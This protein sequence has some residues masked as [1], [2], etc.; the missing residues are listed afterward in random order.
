MAAPTIYTFTM[1]SKEQRGATKPNILRIGLA[2][3][4]DA[5]IFGA[6][7]ALIHSVQVRSITKQITKNDMP[8]GGWPPG[9]PLFA[10]VAIW[11]DVASTAN[12]RLRSLT[13]GFAP[14]AFAAALIAA[15]INVDANTPATSATCTPLDISKI[16]N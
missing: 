4:A 1:L 16:K 7:L 14:F 9:T 2:S 5:L 8:S 3:D 11:S 13:D 15:G 6:N 10:R 12:I